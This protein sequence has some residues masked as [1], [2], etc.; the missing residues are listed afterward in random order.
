M[1]YI[2]S[3]IIAISISFNLYAQNGTVKV[4]GIVMD[5]SGE[6]LIGVNVAVKGTTKGVV[7]DI[8]GRFRINDVPI[9]GTLV[10]SFIGYQTL[11]ISYTSDK[12]RERIGM[13][14]KIDD[15][16]EVVVTARGSQRKISVTG[17]IT[18]VEARELQIP[19]TSVSNMLGARVPGIISV[20]RSGE[21]GNDFSEFWIR[22]ISTF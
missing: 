13:K 10:F 9:G 4:A 19:A 21:P 17:A 16:N 11:E 6:V 2:Y 18:T 14:P 8:D 1:K 12:E 15:L 20:T 22:G 3:L 5:E 7:T